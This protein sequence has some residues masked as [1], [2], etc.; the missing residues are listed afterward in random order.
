MTQYDAMH[1][2][3]SVAVRD[4]HVITYS[5]DVDDELGPGQV[6]VFPASGAAEQMT[7]PASACVKTSTDSIEAAPQEEI[8]CCNVV[9]CFLLLIFG[10]AHPT[11]AWAK[12]MN[13]HSVYSDWISREKKTMR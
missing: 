13:T 7:C 12:S 10:I 1:A 4:A 8:S 2:V 3:P 9:L 6:Q 5:I 11:V